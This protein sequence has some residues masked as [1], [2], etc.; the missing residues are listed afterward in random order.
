MVSHFFWFHLHQ[1]FSIPFGGLEIGFCGTNKPPRIPIKKRLR[2]LRLDPRRSDSLRSIPEPLGRR[3]YSLSQIA[4]INSAEKP[5]RVKSGTVSQTGA[6]LT[7]L[8]RHVRSRIFRLVLGGEI[9]HLVHVWKGVGHVQ[10]DGRC[11]VYGKDGYY[12][13]RLG[14]KCH[15]W[16]E[17][18]PWDDN[19]KAQLSCNINHLTDH[20]DYSL[21]FTCKQIYVEAIDLLYSENVFELDN[22]LVLEFFKATILPQRFRAIRHLQ[23]YWRVK[24]DD[25]IFKEA[26]GK[27]GDLW[28]GAWDRLWEIIA[29][30]MRL[31][32]LIVQLDS[33]YSRRDY[34]ISVISKPMLQV[35]GLTTCEIHELAL[36]EQSMSNTTDISK[37]M[38]LPRCDPRSSLD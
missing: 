26:S 8:P 9:F 36:G 21:I 12:P 7:K 18:I 22:I 34:D 4:L 1:A 32:S 20:A 17:S 11:E 27:K 25:E 38:C 31:E 10:C 19:G 24:V 28:S 2:R 14:R 5:R 29:T 30:D 13:M 3:K 33:Y 37:T 16:M 6:L 15:R 23:L 35:R